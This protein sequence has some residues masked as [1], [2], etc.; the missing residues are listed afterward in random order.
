MKRYNI[1]LLAFFL[2]ASLTVFGQ[3]D[4]QSTPELRKFVQLGWKIQHAHYS[5]D[6]LTMYISALEPGKNNY[7]LFICRSR[8]GIWNAPERLGDFANTDADELWPSISSDERRLYFIRRTVDQ[9]LLKSSHGT[10][11]QSDRLYVAE[12]FRGEWQTAEPIVISSTYDLSP[13]VLPDN[14]TLLFARKE[15]EKKR[16]YY[17]MY[18]TRYMGYGIWTLP[19]RMDSLERRSL[20]GPYLKHLTDNTLQLTEA[21]EVEREKKEYDTLYVSRQMTIPESMRCAPYGVL[22]GVVTDEHS[23]RP[24]EAIIRLYDAIT[25]NL[26]DEASSDAS[27]GR[28]RVALHPGI[29]YNIDITGTNSSHYYTTIDCRD[30]LSNHHLNVQIARHLIVRINPYDAELFTPEPPERE[31]IRNVVTDK[32]MRVKTKRE[33]LGR[34]YELPIG[35]TYAV[36]LFRRGYLDT[37]I[38]VNT[39]RDVRFS[40][41]ELDVPMLPVKK[42]LVLQLGDSLGGKEIKEGTIRLR[43]RNKHE[44]IEMPYTP[45]TTTIMIRQEDEYE[46]VILSP[47]H[48]FF[49]TIVS[50]PEGYDQQLCDVDLK[51]IQKNMVVQLR[52]IQF[53]S[54]SYI[55]TRSS[56]AELE[57]V[58]ALL[59]ANPELHIELSAHT[60]DIG[61]DAYNDQL[62]AKRGESTLEYIVKKG[63]DRSRL[64]SIGYGKHKPLVPNDSDKNRAINRRVEFKVTQF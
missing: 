20:Y 29:K 40:A 55:L 26:L 33:E 3:K 14:Q 25:A 2:L 23:G 62:S 8:A 45:P 18:Y 35:E 58:V 36:T 7:D 4:M 24:V 11:G 61:T 53:E 15:W 32:T 64:T 16:A 39:Q 1:L 50:I 56:Y 19:V 34:T 54:N 49:D 51:P 9:K 28:F 44:V 27:T 59:K 57:K 63:I 46:M 22:T 37:T 10:Q 17:A 6:S 12:N 43:N 41:A 52:N 5:F 38:M 21:Q 60:D 48:F 31:V 30:S 47:G 13:L 42:A